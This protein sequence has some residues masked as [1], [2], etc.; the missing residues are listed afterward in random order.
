M[1]VVSFHLSGLP[2][3]SGYLLFAFIVAE[4]LRGIHKK[5]EPEPLLE[6]ELSRSLFQRDWECVLRLALDLEVVA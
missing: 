2:L 4:F 6:S 3:F 1:L 5:R